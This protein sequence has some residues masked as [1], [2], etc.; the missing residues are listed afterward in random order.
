M[1]H[2][3]TH[4]WGRKSRSVAQSC[5]SRKKAIKDS[6]ALTGIFSHVYKNV[7]ILGLCTLFYHILLLFLI[8][9]LCGIVFW[10]Y[11]F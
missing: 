11:L 2:K 9:K 1:G 4:G 7:L 6:C 10:E 3:A 8:Y 5:A